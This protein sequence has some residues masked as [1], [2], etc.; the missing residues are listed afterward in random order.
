[1]PAQMPGAAGAAM[2]VTQHEERHIAVGGPQAE[3]TAGGEIEKFWLAPDIGDGSSNGAT[4]RYLL[5]RPQKFGHV[6]SPHDDQLRRI[7]PGKGETRPIGHAELLGI[8][9]QLQ[10][11]NGRTPGGY[12]AFGLR[13]G[14]AEARA[15]IPH[16]IGKNLLHQS[17]AQRRKLSIPSRIRATH[18]LRQSRLALNIGNDIAQ[19]RKALV[20]DLGLHDDRLCEQN[21]NI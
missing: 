19:R 7:N 11:K 20:V 1:M 14:K 2:P 13:Q 12:E 18:R 17:A 16:I 9:T 6:R 4:G 21:R 10:V 15:T 3:A 5:G 8:I